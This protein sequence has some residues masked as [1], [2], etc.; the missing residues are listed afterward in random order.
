VPL[1]RFFKKMLYPLEIRLRAKR[2]AVLDKIVSGA[3][4]RVAKE[5]SACGPPLKHRLFYGASAIHPRHLVTWY[6]F[7]TDGELKAAAEIGL[8]SKID[9]LTRR[10]LATG[11]YPEVGI[12]LMHVSFTS[13]EDVDRKAGGNYF[14]YFK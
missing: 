10:E 13:K 5:I 12:P 8:T 1:A 6:I 2:Q 4:D 7:D 9:A 3:T 11:G 14:L